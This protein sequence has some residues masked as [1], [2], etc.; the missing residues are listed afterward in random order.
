MRLWSALVTSFSCATI[1][2]MSAA[3]P[4][5]GPYPTYLFVNRVHPDEPLDNYYG[6]ELGVVLPSYQSEYLFAAYRL[7]MG[8]P[9]TAAQ[10]S[11]LARTVESEEALRKP[12]APWIDYRSE[13]MAANPGGI[14]QAE[15]MTPGG[16][17]KI[18][19]Y[20]VFG[21]TYGAYINCE[22]D[23]FRQALAT[24]DMMR[25]RFGA[26]STELLAWTRAQREVFSNCF[27]SSAV[28]AALPASAPLLARQARRY[29]IASAEFYEGDYDQ[30]AAGFAAVGH[31][32]RSPWRAIAPYLVA[33]TWTRA[34]MIDNDGPARA[35][36]LARAES[37]LR[38]VEHDRQSQEYWTA[39]AKLMDF[40]EFRLHPQAQMLALAHR[41]M[42]AQ[43]PNLGQ[44]AIDFHRLM[45]RFASNKQ[46]EPQ[47]RAGDDL[48]DWIYTYQ[49]TSAAAMLH[50]WAKWRQTR[51]PPWLLAALSKVP[52]DSPEAELL[53]AA[54]RDV[55]A[56]SPA[57]ASIELMALRLQ[58]L[59][60]DTDAVERGLQQARAPAPPSTVN[61]FAALRFDAARTLPE[62]IAGMARTPAIL[63]DESTLGDL[64]MSNSRPTEA[65]F[66][67]GVR[68][69][70]NREVPLPMLTTLAFSPALPEPLHQKLLSTTW[71]RAVLLKRAE[72][73]ERLGPAIARAIPEMKDGVTAYQA[74]RTP[75]ER[76][77]TAAVTMLRLPGISPYFELRSSLNSADDLAIN[78][79]DPSD[80][81]RW[82][83]NASNWWVGPE[84]CPSDRTSPRFGPPFAVYATTY[85]SSGREY[86]PEIG[87][88]DPQ[89][90]VITPPLLTA[91]G[92]AE[93]YTEY[94][95]LMGL[96]PAVNVLAREVITWAE[97]HP[98]DPRDA[99]A[100][101]LA[102]TA[103]SKYMAAC[104]DGQTQSL[105][106][107][108]NAL[109]EPEL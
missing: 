43:N 61:L 1:A 57:H 35:H 90:R 67:V 30:A 107:E 76:Q 50:A 102:V 63:A 15:A 77:F 31:D 56:R 26:G 9:F 85:A 39:A 103:T 53:L 68:Y 32:P 70:L 81:S 17:A 78:Q 58:Y 71:A 8:K 25:V 95:Q 13:W 105:S 22:Q 7:M 45:A 100:L 14:P 74:A 49:D 3:S 75:D 62:L 69:V 18:E 48:V 55:P 108:A 27:R 5:C 86:R 24:R 66:D 51:S 6:G 21:R 106:H 42:S 37:A 19:S 54:G 34:G 16:V 65:Q 80:L 29:Q 94:Q 64:P 41:L 60:G 97:A 99:E 23:A 4:G 72:V 101:K 109:L 20:G 46:I 11:G 96:G 36:L 73:A 33:R 10:V 104:E 2:A 93:S 28:P 91:A 87:L 79:F 83:M 82:E 59:Q 44:E 92:L 40:V 47:L 38:Q 52:P 88:L 12:S 98:A 89:G 84:G